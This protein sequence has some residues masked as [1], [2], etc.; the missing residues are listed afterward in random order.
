M[1]EIEYLTEV[2]EFLK[3]ERQELSGKDLELFDRLM[4]Y[5]KIPEYRE[6]KGTIAEEFR[7]E[8]KPELTEEQKEQIKEQTGWSEEIIEAIGSWEEFELYQK[9]GLVE[10]E[11]AGKKCLIR[12]D[13]DWEQK[14]VMGRTNRERAEQGLSPINRDGKVIELHHVGQHADSPLAEL[15]PEEHRGKGNDTILHDKTKESE[16]DRQVFSEE[17]AGH[18]SDRAEK[19]GGTKE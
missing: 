6:G 1:A 12:G 13:I 18:W 3:E 7:T 5:D 9:A 11:I 8:K 10:A 15:T 19:E 17:R 2:S 4:G 14:D 16:I